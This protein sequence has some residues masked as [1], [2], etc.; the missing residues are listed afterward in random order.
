M[1]RHR[2]YLNKVISL[3]SENLANSPAMQV[4][5]HMHSVESLIFLGV[6]PLCWNTTNVDISEVV[7]CG[8][9]CTC[10]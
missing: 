6:L 1:T 9:E 8:F 10:V 7:V 2:L 3:S 5:Y 4:T